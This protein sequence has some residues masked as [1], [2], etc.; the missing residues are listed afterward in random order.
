MSK[1]KIC[2]ICKYVVEDAVEEC[3]NCGAKSQWNSNMQGRAYVFDTNKSYIGNRIGAKVKG[4]FA[5]KSRS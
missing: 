5:L 3:P 1:K 4:E 2:R